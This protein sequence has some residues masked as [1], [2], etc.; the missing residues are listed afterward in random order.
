[1]DRFYA[2]HDF[3]KNPCIEDKEEIKHISKVLRFTVG[4]KVEIFDCEKKEYIAVISDLRKEKIE[5][6]IEKMVRRSLDNGL[7]TT[8]YQGVVKGNRMEF[9]AQKSTELGVNEIIPIRFH[10]CVAKLENNDSKIERWNKICL[11][12]SKQCK[13]NDVSIVKRALD[14][15]EFLQ[16][17]KKNDFNLFF[18]EEEK[19]TSLKSILQKELR[20]RKIDCTKLL[21]IGL[22]VGPEGGITE[23]E[24]N[25]IR[26]LGIVSLSLGE[27]ILRTETVAMS[28]L[29]MINYELSE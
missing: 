25:Q 26:D 17:L 16:H 24:A 3:E 27:R 5:F 7:H 21:K 11:E 2:N 19:Q 28:V 9:L 10:R 15:K 13:R 14:F 1:M 12:A 6:S 8:L 29:S 4:D 23:D 22:I 18:Y 20:E